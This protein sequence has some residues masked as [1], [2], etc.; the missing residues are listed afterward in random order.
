MSAEVRYAL[1]ALHE[2]STLVDALTTV[3]D[4]RQC[5][6]LDPLDEGPALAELEDRCRR[7]AAVR[8]A[9]APDTLPAFEYRTF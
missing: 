9:T 3:N 6:G 7:L 5:E 1:D 8:T 2:A 4:R